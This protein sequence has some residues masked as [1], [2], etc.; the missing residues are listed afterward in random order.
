MNQTEPR[1]DKRCKKRYNTTMS[2]FDKSKQEQLRNDRLLRREAGEGSPAGLSS[3]LLEL[4]IKREEIIDEIV[5]NGG[6]HNASDST[7]EIFENQIGTIMGYK[8]T[9]GMEDLPLPIEE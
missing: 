6:F 3:Y 9:H 1:V 4:L 8:V 5:E 7:V 2:E